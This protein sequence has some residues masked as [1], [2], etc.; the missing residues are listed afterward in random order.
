M[1]HAN[2]I[3][4]TELAPTLFFPVAENQN[5]NRLHT[6]LELSNLQATYSDFRQYSDYTF[7]TPYCVVDL[8]VNGHFLPSIHTHITHNDK[9]KTCFK[10]CFY[11]LC[12]T[13]EYAKREGILILSEATVFL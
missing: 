12:S 13:I 6:E 4:Q 1:D 5:F 10:K 8:T 9:L 7:C 2:D 11:I 3:I